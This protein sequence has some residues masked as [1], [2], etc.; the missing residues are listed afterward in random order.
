MHFVMPRP[1]SRWSSSV[2]LM[3]VAVGSC[4]GAVIS[5]LAMR[6]VNAEVITLGDVILRNQVRLTDFERQARLLPRTPAEI[7][8]FSKQSL[9]EVTD[10]A[11]LAQRATELGAEPDRDEISLEVL[12][13]ARKSGQGLTLRDQ[14]EQ[15]KILIRR[16]SIDRVIGFYE[17]QAPQATPS[18]LEV[19][20]Q[21]HL[22][23][24][25]RPAR[26]RVLQILIRPS[27]PEERS[28]II[29]E[30]RTLLRN[31]DATEP[32]LQ[33]LVSGHLTRYL[34]S[35]PAGQTKILETLV[36]DLAQATSTFPE[37]A[38]LLAKAKSLQ[39]RT[40]ALRDQ[41]AVTRELDIIRLGLAGRFGP[42]LVTA[43]K[44]AAKTYSQGPGA[45]RGG[46]QGWIEPGRF[47]PAM[48]AQVF[49]A[50]GTGV[51]PGTLSP[52]FWIGGVGA[53]VLVAESEAAR[54]RSFE[55][56]S[57]ELERKLK[58]D[59]RERIRRQVVG[60]LRNRATI[61]DVEPIERLAQ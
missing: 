46:D 45:E 35:D 16:Y 12:E 18:D 60:I 41:A 10:D 55:E 14:A 49:G 17:I 15:R 34:A 2:L 56:V 6:Y 53:L 52:V 9:E 27:A 58:S 50:S 30:R 38:P 3:L 23:A 51:A 28:Q 44:A 32:A 57:G 54:R 22:T 5:D 36:A 29:G 40:E 13:N 48:D 26:A 43:F 20:Y 7:L 4:R 31:A 11:L 25:D 33:Q 59:R 19:F 37:D 21:Q 39:A 47:T 8:A 1:V 24:F 61:R 42:N